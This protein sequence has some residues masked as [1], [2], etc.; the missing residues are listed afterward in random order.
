VYSK[1]FRQADIK[2]LK[3]SKILDLTDEINMMRVNIRC[4][5]ELS[6]TEISVSQAVDVIRALS[7]ST[8]C[9]TRLINTQNIVKPINNAQEEVIQAMT[10]MAAEYQKEWL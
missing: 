10:D 4:L 1:Q 8:I 5:F 6:Q 2:D 9:L 7:L 3:N